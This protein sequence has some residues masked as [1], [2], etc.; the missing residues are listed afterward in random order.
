MTGDFILHF[1]NVHLQNHT[2]ADYQQLIKLKCTSWFLGG[3]I[4]T[5]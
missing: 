2:F 1:E 4:K 5:I 3:K